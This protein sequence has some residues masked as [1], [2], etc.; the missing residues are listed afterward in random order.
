MI[1]KYL[2]SF[3]PRSDSTSQHNN[4]KW[5]EFHLYKRSIDQK[6]YFYFYFNIFL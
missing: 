5:T 2:L 3:G 1:A 4:K 6:N